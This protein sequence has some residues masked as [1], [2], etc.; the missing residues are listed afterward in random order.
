SKTALEWG[1]AN[2]RA[3]GLP[4]DDHD[5]VFG[6]VFDWL[7]RLARR[8]EQFDLVILDPPGF[9]RT[10]TSRFAAAQDYGDLAG[11]AARVVAADGLLLACCNV[12]E[13]PWRAFRERVLAGIA[14]VGRS[15][16]VEAVYHEPALD[17]PAPAGQAPY[18]KIAV[19][20][21][22]ATGPISHAARPRQ[23]E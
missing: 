13:L 14:A 4:V 1:K 16:T 12:A 6:D 8:R 10:K 9:S 22:G 17:F 19:I 20:R 2:Y 11:L 18:L 5:F 7:A 23:G 15:A 3:N 21:L